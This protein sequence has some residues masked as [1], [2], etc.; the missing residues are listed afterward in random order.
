MARTT[1]QQ[2]RAKLGASI[3]VGGTDADTIFT[4]QE[5]A[6]LLSEN[7]D[8]PNAAAYWGWD[9]I[10]ANYVHLVSVNE[11]NA[12]RE[13]TELHRNALRMRDRYAGYV[14]TPSR[15]RARIGKLV[16]NGSPYRTTS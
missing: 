12:S 1:A 2:L 6:D 9:E 3:P 5:I 14:D 13:L 7:N 10:A 15:G 8:D 11:G 16:R 4:D